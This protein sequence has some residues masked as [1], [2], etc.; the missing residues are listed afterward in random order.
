MAKFC[1]YSRTYEY[2]GCGNALDGNSHVH[3]FTRRTCFFGRVTY[4]NIDIEHSGLCDP[5]EPIPNPRSADK[6]DGYIEVLRFKKFD[7]RSTKFD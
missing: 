3:S 1:I 2:N 6:G 7:L 4:K 5:N